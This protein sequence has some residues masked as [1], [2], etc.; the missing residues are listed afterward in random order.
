MSTSVPHLEPAPFPEPRHEFTTEDLPL[1]KHALH[2]HNQIPAQP[3][4]DAVR[5]LPIKR[6]SQ[7]SDIAKAL[8]LSQCHLP[9]T[10]ESPPK[11]SFAVQPTFPTDDRSIRSVSSSPELATMPL[12]MTKDPAKSLQVKRS[13]RNEGVGAA[14]TDTPLSSTQTSPRM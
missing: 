11:S 3:T 9:P 4:E 12:E 10:P 2:H 7:H 6:Q 5:P 1:S 14:A 13:S 8:L